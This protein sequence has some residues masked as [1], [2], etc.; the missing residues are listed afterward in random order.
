MAELQGVQYRAGDV[1]ILDDVSVRFRTRRF[2]MVLG[3]NGAGKSSLLKIATGLVAPTTGQ[4]L[5]EERPI[6]SFGTAALARKRAVLSQQIE[7]AFALT[8]ENVVMM[9]RYPHFGRVPT[10]RDRDIVARALELVGMTAQRDQHY[11]TLS[12][13]EQQK[14]QLARVLAQLWNYD[15][16]RE[17]KFLFLDEPTAGLDIHYR[18]HM[19]DTV[20]ELLDQDCTVVAVLHDL[21]TA[22]QYGDCFFV[23]KGGRIVHQAD[24]S[25]DITRELIEQVYD[26]HAHKI[27]DPESHRELWQFTL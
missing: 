16:P 4:V 27:S 6:A 9:G 25:Q 2:N 8:V 22:L 15:E 12:G 5:Y 17:H 24:R 20:R 7:L 19:L 21:N 26:V 1:L 14:V 3:P 13:G 11:P 18:I 10:A 23:V